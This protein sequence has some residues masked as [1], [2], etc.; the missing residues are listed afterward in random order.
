MLVESFCADR[1]EYE[2]HSSGLA[3]S[4]LHR[5]ADLLYCTST[6]AA[7]AAADE[8]AADADAEKLVVHLKPAEIV[9]CPGTAVG[10]T[11]LLTAPDLNGLKGTIDDF[12]AEAGRYVVLLESPKRSIRLRPDCCRAYWST[13]DEKFFKLMGKTV[14]GMG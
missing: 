13:R 9:F 6:S 12:D 2:L 14:D 8:A 11:G 1:N 3:K 5:F 7:E 4:S 10:V